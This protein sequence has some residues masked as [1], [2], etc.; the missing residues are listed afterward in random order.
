MCDGSCNPGVTQAQAHCRS[1]CQTFNSVASFDSH[2]LRKRLRAPN[3]HG[4]T[5]VRHC[6]T[7]EQLSTVLGLHSFEGVWA[8][9]SY[10]STLNRLET[11]RSG[12]GK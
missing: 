6:A 3:E 11:A 8:P 1:C 7:S 9:P 5:M 2:R 4:E 12:R 10:Q